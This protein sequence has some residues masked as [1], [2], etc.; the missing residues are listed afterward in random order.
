MAT[1]LG[2]R[3]WTPS[4]SRMLTFCVCRKRLRSLRHFSADIWLQSTRSSTALGIR[5]AITLSDLRLL[6]GLNH[7]I[8]LLFRPNMDCLVSIVQ[9]FFVTDR[10]FASSTFTLLHSAFPPDAAI[11][12]GMA[13]ITGTESKH[14]KEIAEIL[15]TVD[16]DLPT[17]VSGDFNSLSTF[18]APTAL[19]KA[20]F[21]DSFACIHADADSHHTWHWPTRPLPMKF[22]IDY[23]FH[24]KHFRTVDSSVIRR[25]GSDHF[26]LVSG[27]ELGEQSDTPERP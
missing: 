21:I 18:Q 23:I 6:P 12:D 22:R 4:L 7:E 16:V 17:I 9:R 26:L 5:A 2:I 11:L 27:L 8:S 1:D 14:A 24:S 3:F 19:V 15:T 10:M 25:N 13:A 20:G